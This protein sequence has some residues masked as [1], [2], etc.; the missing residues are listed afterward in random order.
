[1][2]RAVYK[3]NFV[4]LITQ[5]AEDRFQSNTKQ[6]INIR[7]VANKCTDPI[8]HLESIDTWNKQYAV[9]PV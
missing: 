4:F 2:H 1:M 9:C 7:I 8:I 5:R 6:P 3:R